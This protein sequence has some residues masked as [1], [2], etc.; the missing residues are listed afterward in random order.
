MMRTMLGALLLVLVPALAMAQARNTTG[1][2]SSN[3]TIAQTQTPT[4]TRGTTNGTTGTTT[5]GTTTGATTTN[6]T[7]TGVT[8]PATTPPATTDPSAPAA[9]GAPRDAA[10]VLCGQ[11]FSTGAGRLVVFTASTSEGAPAITPGS[12]CAQA[13]SDLFVA[14]F[15]VIDVLP[16]SQQ[17]QYTL[18]R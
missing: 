18:V 15:G 17:L 9:F 1:S 5:N 8:T 6:G 4:T 13:L 7:T 16:F 14:G 11:E 10:I 2:L 12:S 3:T